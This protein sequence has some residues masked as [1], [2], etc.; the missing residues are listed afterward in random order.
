M[1]VIPAILTDNP[2]ELKE[3]IN[4]CE[5][6]VER[7]SID[8]VDGQFAPTRTIDPIAVSHIETNLK[9]D[10]HLMVIEPVNWLEQCVRGQADRVIGHIEQM[11]SQFEF[12]SKAEELGIGVGLAIDMETS[13]TQIREEIMSDLDVLLVLAVKAGKSGQELDEAVY[14]KIKQIDEAKK[15]AS[16][17][18]RLAVDGGVNEENIGKLKSLGV[19]EFNI[20][21]GLFR[22]NFEENLKKYRGIIMQDGR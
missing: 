9:I 4:V 12:I 14:E 11:S 22:G 2:S 16:Y 13:F 8:I 6:K 19:D 18:F 20:T 10:Y 3:L 5:G 17:D 1:Q 15:A 7:V 21:S